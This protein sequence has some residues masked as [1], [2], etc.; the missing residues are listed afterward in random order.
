[1]IEFVPATRGH[2]EE[3]GQSFTAR[4]VAAIDGERVLGMGG[5][6]YAGCNKE[7]FMRIDD[8]LRKNKVKLY[9]IIK[10]YVDS[11]DGPLYA[12]SDREID[13]SDRL[14]MHLGFK[15]IGGDVWL[16]K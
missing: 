10:K 7:L 13:G 5:V 4:A 2:M 8:E 15:N 12:T 16:R 9:R 11:I 14:L 3:L 6:R 1:M